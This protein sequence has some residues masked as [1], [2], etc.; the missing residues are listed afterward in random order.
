MKEF[1]IRPKK[2]FDEYLKISSQD[3]K[4][5]FSDK[6]SFVEVPCPGCAQENSEFAFDKDG[7]TY[8]Q[9][10]NC[11]SLF[12]SQR[13]TEEM[14]DHFYRESDSS[15]FWAER[16][17]PET[18]EARREMI[19]KPRAQLVRELVLNFK[20]P[21]PYVLVDVG[22]GFGIFLEEIKKVGIFKEM[23]GIEPSID[24]A[25]CLRQKGFSVIEKPV[26]KLD[27]EFLNASVAC[28]FEV[29]EHLFDP[30]KFIKSI[31][32]VLRHDGLLIFTTLTISGLDL[33]VLWNESK[34]ISPPHHINFLSVEGLR[35]LI[36]RCELQEV[37]I[38]TPGKLD[39]D[40]IVNAV[41]ENQNLK[42][43]RFV[44]YIIRSRQDET[45][46]QLQRFLQDNSLSSHA[47]V[48]ARKI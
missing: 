37:E 28:S 44:E 19:F 21:K 35:L 32:K 36:K 11:F 24:L 25:R 22:A 40:I 9:C 48:V 34:S 13:P 46:S 38:T 41:R 27:T 31:A 8:R 4:K 26:E 30:S 29:L 42:L 10:P 2:L 39:V 17:F 1:E 45:F 14:I 18:A 5:F 7:F 47:R 6:K 23:M 3:I 20:A 12:V 15:R 16:F 43:P 33:L